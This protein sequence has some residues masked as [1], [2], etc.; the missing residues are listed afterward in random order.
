MLAVFSDAVVSP[1]EELVQAGSRTPTPKQTATKLLDAFLQSNPCSMA[2]NIGGAAQIAFT[3]RNQSLLQP[4]SFAVNEEIYC[5]FKGTLENL[6]SL[7]QH[8]G[9][10]KNASEVVLVMEAYRAL[11][12]RAPYSTNQML[13]HLV[14]QFAFVVF[15]SVTST[16]FAAA[17]QDGK[18]PLFL[19]I[20]VDGYLA[21]SDETEVLRSA[22]GQS[23]AS[24]PPGC[25]FSTS[26]GIRSY[27]HPKNRVTV[28][29]A[30]DEETW[31]ATFKIERPC[32]QAADE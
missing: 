21:F 23:L 14:G 15:D 26:T 20:T 3:H 28:L 8:Y 16:V 32:S 11:R 22:C 6:P 4:R 31:G 27:E 1:P 25:F 12:D 5:L 30:T 2:L 13:A 7:K 10:A 19:G 17:D 9:L 29:P 18:V 24:F